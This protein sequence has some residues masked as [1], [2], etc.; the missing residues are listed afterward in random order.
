MDGETVLHHFYAQNCTLVQRSP[1][2][3]IKRYSIEWQKNVSEI[4][5]SYERNPVYNQL[6]TV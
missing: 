3:V 6:L 2:K 1:S 4:Y 5:K